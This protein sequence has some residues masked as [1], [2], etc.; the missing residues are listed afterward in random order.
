MPPSPVNARP[1]AVSNFLLIQILYS[2][3]NNAAAAAAAAYMSIQYQ[4]TFSVAI[5]L[6]QAIDEFIVYFVKNNKLL[7]YVVFFKF[8]K[9]KLHGKAQS[10]SIKIATMIY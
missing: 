2:T 5:N 10:F 9:Y 3:V 8:Q 6:H 4:N 1:P 7:R